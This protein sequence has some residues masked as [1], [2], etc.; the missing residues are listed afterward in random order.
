L[1]DA[2]IGSDDILEQKEIDKPKSISHREISPD[3]AAKDWHALKF[4]I[5]ES[6]GYTFEIEF[7]LMV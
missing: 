5:E 6:I 2:E 3:F 4:L 1:G 7:C